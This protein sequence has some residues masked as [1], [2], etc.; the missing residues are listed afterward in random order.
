MTNKSPQGAGRDARAYRAIAYHRL[1]A[2]N[3]AT[4][5][6]TRHPV[7]GA[8]LVRLGDGCNHHRLGIGFGVELH[9]GQHIS[10]DHGGR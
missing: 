7:R 10:A 9:T 6:R 2:S 8:L 1:S 3:M 4:D 5:T